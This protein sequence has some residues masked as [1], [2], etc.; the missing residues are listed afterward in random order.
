MSITR[1]VQNTVESM[2]KGEVFGYQDLP[3]FNSSSGAV[4]KAI[5][6]MVAN[7]RLVRLSKGQFYTPKKG[8]FGIRKPADNEIIKSIL[9]KNWQLTG[10]IT[11]TSLYNKL[12]LTTQLPRTVTIA[13]NASRQRKEYG[14]IAINIVSARCPIDEKNVKLLQYLDAL[15]DIKKI[16]DSNS[17]SS[18]IIIKHYLSKLSGEKKKYIL[19]LVQDYYGPQVRALLGLLFSSLGYK[20]P[21]SLRQSLN[22]TTIFK[23]GLDASKWPMAKEWMIK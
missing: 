13:S 17:N 5:N 14:T 2:A 23:L 18:L 16:P 21:G 12:G 1:A 22:P 8:I 9:Y 3:E 6:R 7:N 11:G 19:E 4:V 10:Y 15:K 20:V